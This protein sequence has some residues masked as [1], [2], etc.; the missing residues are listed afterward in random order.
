MSSTATSP[1]RPG[2]ADG[3]PVRRAYVDL[4]HGQ[5]H[6]ARCGDPAAPAVVLLHQSPRSWLEY[7]HVLPLLGA[8]LHAIAP[9]TPGFG[10]S[11]DVAGPASIEAWVEVLADAL[12]A[13]G[14]H[15]A[16]VVGHHTGGVVAVHLAA[17]RPE[18]VDRLVLSSTPYTGADFRRAR[19]ERPPID[20][21]ARDPDG[22]HLVGLWRGRQGFYPT[23]RPDLLEAF[24]A[25]ALKVVDPEAGHVAVASYRMEDHIGAVRAPV[26]IL[27]ATDDPFASPHAPELAEHLGGAPIVDVEGGMV[28]LPDQLPEAF[29]AAV[30][31]A[32]GV[33]R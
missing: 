18:L 23:D 17:D 12:T 32:V 3:P 9:D 11:D 27:R 8:H 20:G 22:G 6:V 15:R 10:S 25:D 16:H 2:V 4:D 19:A 5:V 29:A 24:V 31:D 1:T 33:A 14:V 30:L 28:P 26:T 7:R 13:L 21:V